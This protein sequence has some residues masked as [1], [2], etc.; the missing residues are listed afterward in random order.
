MYSLLVLG[1]ASCAI[2]LAIT[3]LFRSMAH[4]LGFVDRPDG[5]RKMHPLPTPRV[6]G[7]V[8]MTVYLLVTGGFLIFGFSDGTIARNAIPKE[9][10]IL[11]AA[12][13]VFFTGLLDD[14][15]GLRPWQ[16]LL[17]QTIAAGVAFGIGVRIEE[18]HGAF[19]GPIWSL[20]LTVFWLVLCSNAFNLIDGM[21]GLATGVGL[22]ATITMTLAAILYGDLELAW[23][24][25]P[26]AGALLGFLWYNFNPASVF[27]GD[28]GSLL[29]GFLLGCYGIM[30]SLK[31]ATILGMTAPLMVL[32]VPL[33][34]TALA[35]ARRF[36]RNEPIFG[37][38]RGHIHHR[39]LE[40]GFT[41]RRIALMIY[42]FSGLAGIFSL[43]QSI[44]ANRF[45]P[46]IVVMF[47]VVTS[48]A[49][50][51]LRYVEFHVASRAILRGT[52]RRLLRS[53]IHLQ[54]M[55][56][57]LSQADNLQECWRII[58]D[59]SRDLGFTQVSMKVNGTMYE[60][61]L[62]GNDSGQHWDLWIPF[63][64]SDYVSFQ[65]GFDAMVKPVALT[66]LADVLRRSL[67]GKPVTG[68]RHL[69]ALESMSV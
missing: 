1:L 64:E 12:V 32:C 24:T 46:V 50:W 63:G 13:L 40:R 49:I 4:R 3:P 18:I 39:L 19:E 53:E 66:S 48:L 52:F 33:L 31:S 47:C 25:V 29:V 42:G 59:Q 30:W 51:S 6:G 34:D 10:T 45:S 26:L 23:V 65:R 35:V 16:K 69:P 17:G 56:E 20:L 58:R 5:E 60:A 41:T 9:L 55:E 44:P 36:L 15:I 54:Q 37:A 43:L 38:D 61:N 11:P 28:S 62:D 68:G 67:R 7:W 22:L 57:R 27:L 14:K 21:D 2:A 8:I